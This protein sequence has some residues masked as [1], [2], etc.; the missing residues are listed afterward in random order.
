MTYYTYI[1]KEFDSGNKDFMAGAWL[2]ITDEHVF[3][4]KLKGKFDGMELGINYEIVEQP[5]KITRQG[6][7]GQRW[8]NKALK[9]VNLYRPKK[10]EE[11]RLGLF[12]LL[13]PKEDKVF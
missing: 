2:N 5:G 8:L 11:I 6:N 7:R 3:L 13:Y 4:S 1:L 10:H 9:Q 12:G